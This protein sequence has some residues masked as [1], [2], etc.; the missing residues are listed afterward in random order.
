[1]SKRPGEFELIA[2]L[3]APLASAPGAFGLTDDVA[4]F[5]PPPGNELVLKTDA[6]VE[7]VHFHAT[8]PADSVAKKALRVNLS[9]LAAKGT[10]PV[11]YLLTLNL[12][13]STS[14][15]WLESFARGLA[16]DQKQFG[17]SLYGGDTTATPGPLSISVSM[18]GFIPTGTLTK[19][20]GAKA[21]DLVFVSGTIGDAGGGLAV[22]KGEGHALSAAT[23]EALIARYHLPEP[24]LK[25]GQALRGIASASLDV[26]DGLIADLGHISEV[27]KIRVIVEGPRVPLS[28][29]LEALWGHTSESVSRAATSGDDYEIAFTAPSVK[30]DAV[31]AAARASKTQITEIGRVEA[32]KGVALL[33]TDGKEIAI[34]RAGFTHF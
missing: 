13:D 24:R 7:T 1:M 5:T 8:D 34:E 11:G 26:S 29:A 16:E 30:R 21:G 14:M 27:S 28:H 23:R 19:R 4:M 32:G 18:F 10:N 2:Q 33:D 12:P 22:L 6:I 17:I 31:L 15:E 25:L 9:D 20:A 3:F